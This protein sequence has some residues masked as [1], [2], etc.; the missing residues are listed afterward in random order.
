MKLKNG[1]ILREVAGSTVVVPLDPTSTFCNM[2]RLNETGKFLWE[3]LAADVAEDELVSALVA[4][5]EIDCDTARRDIE[6][7]LN[8][9]R[10]FKALEE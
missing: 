1:Y 9:L 5:Y 8:S 7:F 3:K 10:E 4:E 2:L 6:T